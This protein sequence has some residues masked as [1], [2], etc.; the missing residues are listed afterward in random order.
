VSRDTTSHVV[1]P[2]VPAFKPTKAELKRLREL[3]KKIDALAM[4][5]DAKEV[6]WNEYFERDRA[7]RAQVG[8]IAQDVGLRTIGELPLT[9]REAGWVVA[10]PRKPVVVLEYGV[11]QWEGR[12]EWRGSGVELR[13][14]GSVGEAR[15]DIALDRYPL[16][17]RHL[18][19]SWAPLWLPPKC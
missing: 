16:F 6:A 2:P 13:K 1:L 18:D 8:S 15:G 10:S 11:F 12:L 17:R 19:G 5:R 4:T 3:F 9:L 14:D 7:L